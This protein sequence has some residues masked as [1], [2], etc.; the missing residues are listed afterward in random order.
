MKTLEALANDLRASKSIGGSRED[1]IEILN[2]HKDIAANRKSTYKPKQK[3]KITTR[4][5]KCK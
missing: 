1:I 5:G 2:T 4:S 3:G